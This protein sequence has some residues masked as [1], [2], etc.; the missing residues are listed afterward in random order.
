MYKTLYGEVSHA[1]Q[2]AVNEKVLT[3][4]QLS[5]NEAISG[6]YL[7]DFNGVI[8]TYDFHPVS[9]S[10]IKVLLSYPVTVGCSADGGAKR[11]DC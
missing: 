3:L 7:K 6:L 10:I 8:V 11:E 4:E 1:N 5:R 2:Y 9:G